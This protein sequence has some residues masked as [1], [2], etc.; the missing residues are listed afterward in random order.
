V[1]CSHTTINY[2]T[3]ADSYN[4]QSLHTNLLSPS[5]LVLTDNTGTIYVSPNHT[6]PIS[7]CYSTHKV[8]KSYVKSSQAD[9]L[10]SSSTTNFPWLSPT[11]NWLVPELNKFC[12]LY[13]QGMD[14]HHRKH[15][16]RDHHLPLHDIIADIGNTAS[17]IVVCS[18]VFIE[19]LPGNTLIKSDT[20]SFSWPG[21]TNTVPSHTV[22]V[23]NHV[24]VDRPTAQQFT[25]KIHPDHNWWKKWS[26][27][28]CWHSLNLCKMFTFT[29]WSSFSEMEWKWNFINSSLFCKESMGDPVLF[30]LFQQ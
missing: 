13:S 25:S 17:S 15:M 14:M 27:L 5:A 19:L 9:F 26:L 30:F 1:G 10:Y 23:P 18:T 11:E 16:S 22:H 4:S 24:I 3:I 28:L 21:K 2:N 7:L 29:C 20:I 8:F 12:H 6:L